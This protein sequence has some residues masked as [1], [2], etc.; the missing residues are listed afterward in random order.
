M[1]SRV[2]GPL[3]FGRCVTR[4]GECSAAARAVLSVLALEKWAMYWVRLGARCGTGG[5]G[6]ARALLSS[7]L[8]LLLLL[9]PET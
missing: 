6:G 8:L 5:P 7:L 2:E 3:R 1:G 4:V 9:L